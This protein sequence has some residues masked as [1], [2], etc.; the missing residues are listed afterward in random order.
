[1]NKKNEDSTRFGSTLRAVWFGSIRLYML[2]PMIRLDSVRF[3]PS[4]ERFGSVRFDSIWF[5]YKRNF[6]Q[7]LEKNGSLC[8]L[9]FSELEWN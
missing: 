3:G 7:S 9:A 1:M 5:L 4:L 6:N 8:Q 2:S